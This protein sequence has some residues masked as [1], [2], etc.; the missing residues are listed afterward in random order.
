MM[1]QI[2][3]GFAVFIR[4]GAK[5][6]G[7]VRQVRDREL[8]VYVENAGDF[9]LPRAAVRDV[10]DEKVL[11]DGARLPPRLMDAI[12]RAHVGEDPRIP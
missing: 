2:Q 4:D 11:L 10:H 5:S 9:E 1:E 8:V 7:A 3:E 6:F 12:A